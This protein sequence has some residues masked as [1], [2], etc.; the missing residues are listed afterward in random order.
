MSTSKSK[1][2]A[3]KVIELNEVK[4]S[5]VG[6]TYADD[7]GADVRA[8]FVVEAEESDWQT[9]RTRYGFDAKRAEGVDLEEWGGRFFLCYV[10]NCFDP[11]VCVIRAENASEAEERFTDEKDWADVGEEDLKEANPADPN[12][13]WLHDNISWTARGTYYSREMVCIREL[14]MVRVDLA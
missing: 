14:R 2:G 6:F 11:C 5:A 10:E 9:F 8:L 3:G 1:S 13:L 12:E 7:K 4:A